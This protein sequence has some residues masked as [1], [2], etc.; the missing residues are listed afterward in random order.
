MD[1]SPGPFVRERALHQHPSGL[2]VLLLLAACGRAP[3]PAVHTVE[4]HH[5]WRFR[6]TADTAWLP[7]T[8]PGTVHTDLLAAGR[9]SDPFGGDREDELRWIEDETWTYHLDFDL[10][11]A[12][13]EAARLELVFEGLDTWASVALNGVPAL[14]A[15]NMFRTWRADVG[16]AARPGT[17]TLEVRF[18]PPVREGAARAAA[19]PWPIPH[20]EP[21][22][23]G[24]RAFSR[25]AAYHFGWDWGPRFVT[26]GIWRPVRLEAWSGVR[27]ADAAVLGTEWVG[28]DTARVRVRVELEAAAGAG[29]TPDRTPTAVRL[30]LRS[31]D[32]HFPPLLIRVPAPGPGTLV[33]VDTTLVV[34][35]AGAWWP[36]GMGRAPGLLH[37]IEV[38]AVV[39][40]SW[41][42]RTLSAGFRT[43]ELVREPDDTGE[44]FLFRVNG[45]AVFA[46]GAN[47]V[48]PDHFTPRADSAAY[49]RLIDDAVAANMNM[50]RVWGGGV[51]L[52][53][54]FYRLADAAGILVWQDF[55]FANT[56]VPGDDAF[57]ASVQA[58]AEDQVRRLRGHPSLALW[59]GNNEMAEGWANWGWRAA[60]TPETAERVEAAYHRIFENILPVVVAEHDPQRPYWPSSPSIGWGHAE[61]L[62]QGD[63]HYWGVW[64]GMEPFRVY[65]EKVPRFASE[66][67]F[68]ALPDGATLGAFG[69]AGPRRYADTAMRAHQKHPRGFE[70]IRAYVERDWP[71]PPDDSLDA[72]S[73][74]S[75]LA[76]A[77][78]VGLALEAHRR[79]WPR[80]GGT[81]YWQLN[82]TWPVVSWSSVDWRG[83]W[84]ALHYRARDVFAPVAVLADAWGDTVAVWVATDGIASQGPGH[85]AATLTVRSLDFRGGELA[86][87]RAAVPLRG[88]A[89][90]LAWRGTVT[91]L[92]PPGADRREVVIEA[93]LQAPDGT[94]ARDLAFLAPP[95]ALRLPDPGLRI[96]AAEPEGAVWAVTVQTE[97]FAYGVHLSLEGVGARWS[98]N[99]MHLLPG[100]R[101]TVRITPETPTP[102]LPS[103]LRLRWLGLI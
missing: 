80:T 77:E 90:V 94:T 43:V 7:A 99:Y 75:Q 51:Y 12:L 52:P 8:V 61:S 25:K 19:H 41:D 86:T 81:L 92:L 11:P 1:S 46:R 64:W 70:T 88:D 85:A 28:R 40:R 32:G 98:D 60:Y 33:T 91:D 15:D 23:A 38:D 37:A 30:G 4:L 45:E 20:Q 59:C 16:H 89:S 2:V 6:G 48:P 73:H 54:V 50:L 17:N 24:T 47:V 14:E 83:R 96:V 39:G 63:S 76:Q 53:D 29:G 95:R 87:R 55:M 68:Q 57:A 78:G 102:D 27:I 58:E 79:S 97:G 103:R 18:A 22:E 35:G 84:K 72:W 82:D 66:F 31:P 101:R 5:G 13:L 21:D 10:D 36:R 67:G 56:M 93:R 26:S 69:G 65:A 42:R 34:H 49:T 62:L 9:I 44:S 3:H 100:E 71:V 74:V